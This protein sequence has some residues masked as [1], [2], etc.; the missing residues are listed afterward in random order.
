MISNVEGAECIDGDFVP[1]HTVFLACGKMA[2]F[3]AGF[4]DERA[5]SAG[6][7][8]RLDCLFEVRMMKMA[9]N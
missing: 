1:E 3:F 2:I 7:G 8:D 4:L 5:N 6:A 9:A